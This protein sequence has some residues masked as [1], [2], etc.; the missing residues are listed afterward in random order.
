MGPTDYQLTRGSVDAHYFTFWP[1]TSQDKLS[2]SFGSVLISG[3]QIPKLDE[4]GQ[5]PRPTGHS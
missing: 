1:S 2:F 5:K 4:E 3:E